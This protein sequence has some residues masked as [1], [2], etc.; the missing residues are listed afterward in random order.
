MSFLAKMKKIPKEL[1]HG[2]AS[3]GL[4]GVLIDKGERY[5]AAL[6]FGYAKG[7][8]YDRFLWK[9]HG[10]DMWIGVGGLL[11]SAMLNAF[12]GGRSRLAPHIERI[13]DAGVMSALN[14]LGTA[15]GAEKR[16]GGAL[17]GPKVKGMIGA[18]PPAMGGAYLTPEQIAAFAKPR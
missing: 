14:T 3:S 1:P 11:A 16:T 15:W 6:A 8:Y 7:H 2:T 4:K 9:G 18:I 17:P 5:G 13:A 12:S 10:A